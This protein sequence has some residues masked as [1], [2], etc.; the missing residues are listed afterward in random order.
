MIKKNYM[1]GLAS[2][3]VLAASWK[4]LVKEGVKVGVKVGRGIKKVSAET[5]EDIEDASAEA[6]QDLEEEENAAR[7]SERQ[8]TGRRRKRQAS[9]V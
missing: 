9:T 6:M 7:E 2:G 8:G 5:L 1:L 4:F 3:V